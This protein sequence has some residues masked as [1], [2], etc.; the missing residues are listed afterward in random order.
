MTTLRQAVLER[1]RVDGD[2]LMVDEFL[3][4]RVE[5]GIVDSAARD[6][7]D[8]YAGSD[9]DLVLTAEASG[10]APA[11]FCGAALQVP[12]V[13]AK[14]YL[15]IGDRYALSRTIT[16]PTRGTEYR[17]EVSR[18]AISP[19]ER[20]LVVD[21]FLS[22][23]RT[24]A[25]LGEITTEAGADVVGFGFLIE[26]ATLGGRQRLE[27]RSWRVESVVTITSLGEGRFEVAP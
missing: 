8:R 10:I 9:I 23:G 6:L 4:H 13:Y 5:L 26:K 11:I 19:A 21:D 1:A 16:S 20:V 7:V 2:L 22:G 27:Q 17:V 24:A 15:G 12:V 14:K 3:N 18:R 25:A